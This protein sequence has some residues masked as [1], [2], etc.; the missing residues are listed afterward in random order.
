MAAQIAAQS[1]DFQ[2]SV[3]DQLAELAAPAGVK[4]FGGHVAV[5]HIDLDAVS[6]KFA[7]FAD[8]LGNRQAEGVNHHAD[9]ESGHGNTLN[10]WGREMQL[11]WRP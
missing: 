8:A 11:G 5:N 9:F 3:A 1:R 4:G 2:A 7:G 6:A 10:L